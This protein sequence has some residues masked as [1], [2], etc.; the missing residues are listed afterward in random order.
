MHSSITANS[1]EKG[2]G[3]TTQEHTTSIEGW[4]QIFHIF[5]HQLCH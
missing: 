3:Q 2:Q 4:K 5:Y 1:A